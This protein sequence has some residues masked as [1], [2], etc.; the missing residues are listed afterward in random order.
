MGHL[1]PQL[2]AF[3]DD[4]FRVFE[5]G[6]IAPPPPP[7][8]LHHQMKPLSNTPHTAWGMSLGVEVS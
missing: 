6:G 3:K 4:V 2:C 8:P 1:M 5:K 7:P